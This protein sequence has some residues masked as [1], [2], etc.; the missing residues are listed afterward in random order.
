MA[1]ANGVYQS[2]ARRA[3]KNSDTID[4]DGATLKAV[5]VK[6][7]HT[8]NFDTHDFLDDIPTADRAKSTFTTISTPSVGGSATD[9]AVYVG[10][11]LTTVTFASVTTGSK[12]S[13]IA[14][15]KSSATE[16]TSPLVCMC[17]FVAS[18]TAGGGDVTVTVNANGILKASYQT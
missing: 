18:V 2:Y 10:S 16:A 15:F 17:S 8:P 13:A 1:P 3:V 9:D 5:L 14:I 4:L 11:N 7:S 12:C 6:N